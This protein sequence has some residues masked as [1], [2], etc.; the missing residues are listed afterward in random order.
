[1]EEVSLVIHFSSL[2][3]NL[4]FLVTELFHQLASTYSTLL[5]DWSNCK[6][7]QLSAVIYN[8]NLDTFGKLLTTPI[9]CGKQ[10]QLVLLWLLH[11]LP[12]I[13]LPG[14]TKY[15]DIARR[16]AFKFGSSR[17]EV[18]KMAKPHPV[19]VKQNHHCPTL[20]SKSPTS[21]LLE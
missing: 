17:V 11:L 19:P 1:M 8:Y 9:E 16:P 5:G 7:I 4:G 3:P 13:F 2:C 15:C 21:S 6:H 12:K 10:T 18:N 20:T 14:P